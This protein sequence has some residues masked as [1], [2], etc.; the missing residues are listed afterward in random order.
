MQV[1]MYVCLYAF[2]YA[3]MH[4][5]MYACMHAYI[6]ACMHACM[7]ACMH[8][9]IYIY[10]ILCAYTHV[11]MHAC[12]HAYMHVCMHTIFMH[13]CMHACMHV[14]IWCGPRY[15]LFRPP[16]A[17]RECTI[18]VRNRAERDQP[19]T[20]GNTGEVEKAL[21]PGRLG[22]SWPP[23]GLSWASPGPLLG[24]LQMLVAVC[25]GMWR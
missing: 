12:M 20:T 1:W 22:L 7:Y 4:A 11:C 14:C 21:E 8:A 13:A 5:C 2:M 25:G 10:A 23:L 24:P 6:F 16:Q 17:W 15:I 3:C 9:Y 18:L 19:V